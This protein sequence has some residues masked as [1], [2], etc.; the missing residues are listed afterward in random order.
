ENQIPTDHI[1]IIDDGSTDGTS[2]MLATKFPEVIVLKGDGNLFWTAAIN[3][4]IRHA[5]QL[6]A[7]Y[8]MTLNND[9]IASEDFLKQMMHWSKKRPSALLGAL[10][11]DVK[12]KEPY[13]GGEIIN[14]A[15]ARSQYLLDELQESDRHGLHEV[16]LFPARGLLIPR[17]V[18]DTVGLFE[19]KL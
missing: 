8:V 17:K 16:S 14:W 4:G 5:L 13:Y 1:I 11:V 6:G 7:E 18:F 10:D 15:L 9:T 2:E 19:E 3:M 12:S